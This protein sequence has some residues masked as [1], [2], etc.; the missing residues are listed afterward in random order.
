MRK[1]LL[2]VPCLLAIFAG[3]DAAKAG[4]A[5]HFNAGE[6]A[7]H[8]SY[9]QGDATQLALFCSSGFGLIGIY[10]E[11]PGLATDMAQ[12][13][14]VK[15]KFLDVTLEYPAGIVQD[16]VQWMVTADDPL[17]GQLNKS[18]EINILADGRAL[19]VPLQGANFTGLV[20]S[21]GGL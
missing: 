9:G 8:L 12:E 5:W 13:I 20:Q 15:V 14:D 21:C 1:A 4:P 6:A 16:G 2:A 10:A 3:M 7:S 19:K 18:P 17:W 11:V